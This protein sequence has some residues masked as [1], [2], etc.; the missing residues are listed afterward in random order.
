MRMLIAFS[1]K[2]YGP[3]RDQVVFSMETA[4]VNEYKDI[5]TIETSHGT[6]LKSAFIYGANG[7]GKTNLFKAIGF[8][9]R[10]VTF[11]IVDGR[12][13]LRN[14]HF[15][16]FTSAN[17]MPTGFEM[18]FCKEGTIWTYGF[19]LLKGKVIKEWLISKQKRATKVF[20]RTSPDW[21]SISLSGKW[22]KF[23]NIREHTRDNALFLSLAAML[24]VAPAISLRGWFEKLLVYTNVDELTPGET[25]RLL[26]E[27][28]E[29]KN[30]ILSF[31][32]VADFG[33]DDFEI[34]VEEED[35]SENERQDALKSIGETP[36][37]V[38][39]NL[40]FKKRNIDLNTIHRTYDDNNKVVG[41][42]LL[43]FIKYQSTGT[44]KMFELLGPI[45]GTLRK[46]G[47]LI[48]D[49][50]DS[51]LHPL[52]VRHIVSLFNSIDKN[53]GNGQLICN[54]HDVL[55]LD[56]PIRRDQYWFMKKTNTGASE[57][58][59]LSDFQNVRKNDSLVKKY[60][61]GIFGAVPFSYEGEP[62]AQHAE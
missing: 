5:N 43:P 12:A 60:L 42:V 9:K 6:Y 14:S 16:F 21:K 10:M 47:T 33:I 49:E 15:Q 58:Y 36:E 11:S 29:M 55:L 62:E 41:S 48:L 46:G 13:A 59:P 4:A 50:I 34:E 25:V 30:E 26:E 24:N 1:C 56:E 27:E 20:E 38:M 54:T 44:I 31:L 7:S 51:K 3:F 61:V 53:I 22:K 19:E 18:I 40:E 37:D 39:M 35:M 8:M 28:P 52:L 17:E 45:L 32:K 2:N 57:L 23:E